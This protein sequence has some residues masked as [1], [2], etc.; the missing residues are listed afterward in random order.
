MK[1]DVFAKIGLEVGVSGKDFPWPK[2]EVQQYNDFSEET[3]SGSQWVIQYLVE[4]L[5]ADARIANSFT[6]PEQISFTFLSFFSPFS[7][8]SSCPLI[9]IPELIFEG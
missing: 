2:S 3:F 8:Q 4:S 1:Q 6:I 9:S 5:E 7:F